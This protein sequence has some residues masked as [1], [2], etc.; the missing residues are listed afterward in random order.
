MVELENKWQYPNYIRNP[1]C[2][3]DIK[4]P[5]K[6]DYPYQL[7]HIYDIVGDCYKYNKLQCCYYSEGN[8]CKLCN[9]SDNCI[10]IGDNWN[11][12]DTGRLGEISREVKRIMG[13]I[14]DLNNVI[15]EYLNGSIIY[16]DLVG[17]LYDIRLVDGKVEVSVVSNFTGR[18][19]SKVRELELELR[20]LNRERSR[21]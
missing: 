20:L 12:L 8:G 3:L 18:I 6:E 1:Y 19:R 15:D 10:F 11:I 7:E 21:L 5:K 14:H 17:D 4:N 9:H 16:Y 13:V 2:P